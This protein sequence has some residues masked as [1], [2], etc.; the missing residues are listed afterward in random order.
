MDAADIAER[1]RAALEEHNKRP[2][3]E[4]PPGRRGWCANCDNFSP[5]L[6]SDHCGR[7]RDLK[8]LA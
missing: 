2:P 4:L 3:Y 7:C 5:R 1:D 8:G 6:I